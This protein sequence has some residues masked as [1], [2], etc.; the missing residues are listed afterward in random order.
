M[1]LWCHRTLTS[2]ISNLGIFIPFFPPNAYKYLVPPNALGTN[3]TFLF[4][5]SVVEYIF[6]MFILYF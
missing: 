4:A 1:I 2:F 3:C 5:L 6:D